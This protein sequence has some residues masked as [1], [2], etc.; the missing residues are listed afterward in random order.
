MKPPVSGR[1]DTYF[2]VLFL[3]DAHG[4]ISEKFGGHDKCV[5]EVVVQTFLHSKETVDH[6][7]QEGVIE[8]GEDG[9]NIEKFGN[10]EE[11]FLEDSFG[12]ETLVHETLL[13]LLV[14]AHAKEGE[15]NTSEE[16]STIATDGGGQLIYVGRGVSERGRRRGQ[17]LSGNQTAERNECRCALFESRR[18]HTTQHTTARSKHTRAPS[19]ESLGANLRK[20]SRKG[21][22]VLSKMT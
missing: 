5:T 6:L 17:F 18:G 2:W 9:A 10:V 3:L 12:E 21:T 8:F 20:E 19:R 1:L 13:G 22:K 7:G 16:S 15:E 4:K 14:G 11:V